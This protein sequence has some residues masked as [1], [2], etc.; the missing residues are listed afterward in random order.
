[1]VLRQVKKSKMNKEA[2]K[3]LTYGGVMEIL[4]NR[5]FYYRSSIGAQYCHLT[6]EGEK[7]LM[8]YMKLMS[9]KMIE[10]EEAELNRRA[11][12]MVLNTLKGD[13]NQSV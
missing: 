12:D 11:K 6:D 7:A 5:R 1:M 9:F 13:N 3:D 4:R 8:E 10:A 2:V